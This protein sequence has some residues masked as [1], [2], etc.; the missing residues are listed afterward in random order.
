MISAVGTVFDCDHDLIYENILI[1]FKMSKG[2]EFLFD[3]LELF[4][5]LF[6]ESK[7]LSF[8]KLYSQP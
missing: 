4:I 1:F 7:F 8:D 3:L 6:E 5:S 2:I